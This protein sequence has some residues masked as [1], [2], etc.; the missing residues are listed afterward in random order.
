MAKTKAGGGAKVDETKPE[1][2]QEPAVTK[3]PKPEPGD[4]DFDKLL[5]EAGVDQ[6]KTDKPKIDKK[7][8]SGDDFKKGMGAIQGK[9][10]A[11]FKGTQG[12]AAV[13]LTIAP[14]GQ[15]SKVTVGGV[16]AGKPEADC[17]TA[18]VKAA[19]F[20][21]WDGGPQSFGYPIL[22]SE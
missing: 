13:K 1:V 4:P 3:K 20:P 21:A 12:T 17:V 2:K 8:L 7:Q 18:A 22:L 9:A 19:Q 6:K 5:K 16:F 10:Q 11:C 14:S 15:V